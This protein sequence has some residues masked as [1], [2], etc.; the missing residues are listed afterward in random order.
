M[1][2]STLACS[3]VA[4]GMNTLRPRAMGQWA[5]SS[6]WRGVAR[7][8]P[9]CHQ[10]VKGSSRSHASLAVGDVEKH[11]VVPLDQDDDGS[12]TV[13]VRLAGVSMTPIRRAVSLAWRCVLEK[14]NVT[15]ASRHGAASAPGVP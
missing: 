14:Y 12:L 8:V 13:L 7:N 4:V 6:K 10:E 3:R 15:A 1:Q 5:A 9:G 11:V 2:P